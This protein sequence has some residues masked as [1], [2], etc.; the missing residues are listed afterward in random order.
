MNHILNQP[1]VSR[2]DF[3]RALNLRCHNT[4]GLGLMDLPDVICIDDFWYEGMEEKEA[5]LMLDGAIDDLKEELNFGSYCSDDAPV[6]S[7]D[8]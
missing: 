1:T 8:E 6:Y 7:I 4:F 5:V 3:R 2:Q